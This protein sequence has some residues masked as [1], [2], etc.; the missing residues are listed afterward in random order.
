MNI[1]EIAMQANVSVAALKRLDKLKVLKCDAENPLPSQIKFALARNPRLT[2]PHTLALLD[3]PD[4]IYD[5]GVYQDRALGQLSALGDVKANAAPVAVTAYLRAASGGDKEACEIVG[6]WLNRLLSSDNL[7]PFVP[8]QWIAVHLLAGM[9]PNLRITAVKGIH[10]V[11]LHVRRN[12]PLFDSRFSVRKNSAYYR[13]GEK[14]T[15]DL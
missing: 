1:Y 8:Y 15:L 13:T 12:D 11:L 2:V 10:L 14:I 7:Q 3:E 6:A 9:A 5:L 4:L